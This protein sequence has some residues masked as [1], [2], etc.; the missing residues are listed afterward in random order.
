MTFLR[1]ILIVA[2]VAI[3][4]AC[5]KPRPAVHARYVPTAAERASWPKT[6]DEAATRLIAGMSDEEKTEVRDTPK[7]E[8]FRFHSVWGA[9]IR[10]EFGLWKGNTNLLADCHAEWADDASPVIIKAVWQKL[11]KP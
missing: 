10:N 6:L 11:Q 3:F 4:V 1:I 2:S 9:G 5:Q 8:L 7:S